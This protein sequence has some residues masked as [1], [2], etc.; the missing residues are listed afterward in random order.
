M[1]YICAKDDQVSEAV[2]IISI[3]LQCFPFYDG[4]VVSANGSVFYY[5]IF[6]FVIELLVQI[7]LALITSHIY[8]LFCHE[9]YKQTYNF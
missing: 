5:N 4:G 9:T 1:C 2:G 6:S 3:S 7:K 8:K